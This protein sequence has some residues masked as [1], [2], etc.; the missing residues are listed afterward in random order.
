MSTLS[1]F[2]GG[3]RPPKSLI[4][5][6]SS[7]G[8]TCIFINYGTPDALKQTLTGAVVANTLKTVLSITGAGEINFAGVVSNDT[9]SR[10]HRMK[11]TIDGYVVFDATSAACIASS[12]G[13][14]A[15]GL[16]SP[17]TSGI[18]VQVLDK[19]VFNSSFLIE[20]A[21]SISETDKSTLVTSYKTF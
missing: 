16:V 17:I 8:A 21:S 11:V 4:N 1:Q 20:Y 7:S 15:I 19:V 14:V 18:P 10:T 3:S 6:F 13:V 5:A 12:K 9:T 2:G